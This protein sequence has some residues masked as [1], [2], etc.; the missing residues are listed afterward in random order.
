MQSLVGH[1]HSE[2]YHCLRCEG[3][4]ATHYTYTPSS[5]TYGYSC[6]SQTCLHILILFIYFQFDQRR[7]Y[8]QQCSDAQMEMACSLWKGGESISNAAKVAGVPSQMLR[9]KTCG[10]AKPSALSSGPQR[11]LHNTDEENI[12]CQVENLAAWGIGYTRYNLRLLVTETAVFLRKR[13]AD[14]KLISERWLDYFLKRW[15]QMKLTKATPLC[16]ARSQSVSAQALEVYYDKLGDILEQIQLSN[17][18]QLIF[19]MDELSWLAVPNMSTEAGVNDGSTLEPGTKSLISCVSATGKVLP[20]YIVVRGRKS[21]EDSGLPT[22][23]NANASTVIQGFLQQHFLLH[24]SEEQQPAPQRALILYDGHKLHLA[25]PL[26][27]WAREW[28]IELFVL[29]PH[30]SHV[31][32]ELDRECSDLYRQIFHSLCQ[33]LM[34][35][36]P[37]RA[38]DEA[39]LHRLVCEAHGKALAPHSIIRTF[40]QTGVHPFNRLPVNH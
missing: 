2:W 22:L 6:V 33:N 5:Q 25:P 7:K 16:L 23:T 37:E 21:T 32:Q 12:V 11:L 19:I 40:R 28:G 1:I 26:L 9:N 3:H 34:A 13:E 4:C 39:D 30:A 10:Y 17:S 31:L 15:P 35:R 24:M 38:L 36:Q 18:P 8:Y 29:P 14:S 27:Q 20:P